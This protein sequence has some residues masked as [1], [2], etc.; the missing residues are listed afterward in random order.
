MDL[1]SQNLISKGKLLVDSLSRFTHKHCVLHPYTQ[2]DY[3]ETIWRNTKLLRC[4]QPPAVRAWMMPQGE[5]YKFNLFLF[6]CSALCFISQPDSLLPSNLSPYPSLHS[7][8]PSFPPFLHQPL[9][10]TSFLLSFPPP[11]LS[12]H[13]SILSQS[14]SGNII[15]AW[16]LS[17]RLYF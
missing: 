11:P 3:K 5:H 9:S 15:I 4:L 6:C 13:P 8:H 7:F 12:I 17:V 10:F 14:Q 2:L 1:F 16:F